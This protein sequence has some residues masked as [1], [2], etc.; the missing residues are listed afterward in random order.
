MS[1]HV[2]HQATPHDERCTTNVA[3][4][5]FLSSMRPP[6]LVQVDLLRKPTRTEVAGVRP[7]TRMCAHV[8]VQTPVAVGA[9]IAEGA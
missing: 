5:W 6:V 4:E 1:I 3:P 2:I 9:V 7:F 8:A